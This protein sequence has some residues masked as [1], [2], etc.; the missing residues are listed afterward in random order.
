KT[1]DPQHVAHHLSY[2]LGKLDIDPS[3]GPLLTD[4]IVAQRERAKTL[5]EMAAASAFF[6]RDFPAYEAKDADSHLKPEALAVLSDVRDRLSTLTDWSAEAIHAVVH[7]VADGHGL[8]LGKIAQPL[9]VA[10]AGR[11]VSPPIDQTLVLLGREKTLA[12]LE[13]AIEYIR[14]R[15][16]A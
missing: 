13:R 5:V 2:H 8:K 15:M 6:Y 7:A 9:R 11:A 1:S 3:S 14:S 10:V 16:P 4:V 12:R